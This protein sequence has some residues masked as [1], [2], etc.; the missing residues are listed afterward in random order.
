MPGLP[1][2]CRDILGLKEVRRGCVQRDLVTGT[3]EFFTPSYA[4]ALSLVIY[5]SEKSTE[6]SLYGGNYR[7]SGSTFGKVGKF[8]KGIFG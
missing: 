1:S 5:A 3:E 8:F 4:T 6:E 2:L 7:N